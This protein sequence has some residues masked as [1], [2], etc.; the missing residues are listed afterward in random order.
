MMDGHSSDSQQQ[1]VS[2]P[3][4]KVLTA[5]AI[6]V[7]KKYWINYIKLPLMSRKLITHYCCD[8]CKFQSLSNIDFRS[9][10]KPRCRLCGM[11]VHLGRSKFTKLRRKVI[12]SLYQSAG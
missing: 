2:L 12:L 4:E 11:R 8:K 6:R 9:S 10:N 3:S 5:H 7:C 1:A